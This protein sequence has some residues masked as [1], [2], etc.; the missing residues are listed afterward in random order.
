MRSEAPVQ[1]PPEWPVLRL[2]DIVSKIGSGA[3]P[4]GGEDA[5]LPVR[6]ALCSD[7]KPGRIGSPASTQMGSR[8]FPMRKPIDYGG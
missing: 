8:I 4:T 2:G 6:G 3:T 5:Y 1:H 7:A